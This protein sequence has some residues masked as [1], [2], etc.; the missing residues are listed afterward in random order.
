VEQHLARIAARHPLCF[1]HGI[2]SPP[3][4]SP[5]RRRGSRGRTGP[6]KRLHGLSADVAESAMRIRVRP[7]DNEVSP[8]PW[9]GVGGD[10][11]PLCERQPTSASGG[12]RRGF[13][14]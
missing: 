6:P 10:W 11:I 8:A 12:R 13:F 9:P 4:C 2:S 1:G 14:R 7:G 3:P 5:G